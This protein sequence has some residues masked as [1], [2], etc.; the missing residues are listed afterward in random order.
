MG[1]VKRNEELRRSW[2]AAANDIL[3][4][5]GYG[6]LK[7][8]PLC[9]RLGVTTGAFYHSF[10]SWQEFTDSLLAT[11]LLD[12]TQQ[13]IALAVTYPDPVQRL[14]RLAAASSELQ[15]R[16]EAAIRVW[17]GV[18]DRVAAVQRDVD[19]DR[20]QVVHDA[21]T[22]LVGPERAE[23]FTVWAMSTLVGYEMLAD[24]HDRANLA[25]ALDQIMVAA[26]AG[27]ATR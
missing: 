8:A 13:T 10:A 20:F 9:Q 11:W 1:R 23:A 6:G 7:L 5:D 21:M 18:D 17:A 15:H 22:A 14:R 26:R 3:A 4:S 24:Q 27:A 19:A 25:W 12:R 16:T 2:F